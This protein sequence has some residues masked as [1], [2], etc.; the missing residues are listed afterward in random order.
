MSDRDVRP[1]L[2]T[3]GELSQF[4]SARLG[5]TTYD[6]QIRKVI[7]PS[8]ELRFRCSWTLWKTRLVKNSFICLRR[9]EVVRSRCPTKVYRGQVSSVSS[10]QL[11]WL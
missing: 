4:R 10:G 1:S 8:S 7:T 5:V 2:P 6:L 3:L 11:G 9:I